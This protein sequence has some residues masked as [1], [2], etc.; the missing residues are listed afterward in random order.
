M[1]ERVNFGG[2]RVTTED[3]MEEVSSGSVSGHVPE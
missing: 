3:S 2:T 1:E